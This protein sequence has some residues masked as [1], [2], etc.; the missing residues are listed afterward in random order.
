MRCVSNINKS[1]REAVLM[2]IREA[3]AKAEWRDTPDERMP[4][5]M[6]EDYGSVWSSEPDLSEFWEIF[7]RM[8]KQ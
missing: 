3:G 8:K 4:A 6:R 1:E 7:R 2:A 5:R